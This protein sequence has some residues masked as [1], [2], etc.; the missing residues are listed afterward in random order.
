[1]RLIGCLICQVHNKI[2]HG[3]FADL[4]KNELPN[5]FESYLI[6]HQ[7]CCT[8]YPWRNSV[9]AFQAIIHNYRIHPE[10]IYVRESTEDRIK[11]YRNMRDYCVKLVD[12]HCEN[13]LEMKQLPQRMFVC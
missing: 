8:R 12:I 10:S 3:P 9:K 7:I 13:L 4:S 5:I 11:Q 2:R 6:K 1:M